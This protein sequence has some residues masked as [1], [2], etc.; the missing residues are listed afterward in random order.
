VVVSPIIGVALDSVLKLG[1]TMVLSFMIGMSLS[2]LLSAVA[3]K[4]KPALVVMLGSLAILILLIW[5][6]NI[7]EPAQVILPLVYW[8][9]LN[10]QL[11]LLSVIITLLFSFV[12]ISIVKERFEK[13]LSNYKSSLLNLEPNFA[14]IGNLSSIVA[15]E[16]IE[17]QRS[18]LL[19]Q[20]SAGLVG[21]LLG[22]YFLV[23][24]M[25]TG[26]GLD[27]PFNVVS[28]SGFVGFMGV[29]TYSWITNMEHN[30]SLNI[31]PVNVGEVVQA[32]F[33]IHLILT[34]C[35]SAVCVSLIA[36]ARNEKSMII[37]SLIVAIANA[38]YSGAIT[39][40]LTGLWTNTLFFDARVII[41]FAAGVIPPLLVLELISLWIWYFDFAAIQLLLVVSTVQ[42]IAAIFLLKGLKERWIGMPFSFDIAR[43]QL[44]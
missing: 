21:A 18:G 24:L 2:F 16:W 42:I 4:S 8:K 6:F 33:V 12:A 15:K 39:A 32:K 5:P 13:K 36:I 1:L 20:V 31:L 22:V 10:P 38:I 26:I 40:R 28:Y 9:T 25:E 7:L 43:A 19:I 11:L 14:F 27:L 29:I 37:L 34:S 17:L 41:K 35:I 3:V 23:W 44:K 30:E